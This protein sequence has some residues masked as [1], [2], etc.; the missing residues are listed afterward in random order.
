ML[1]GAHAI[2]IRPTEMV[3]DPAYAR[4]LV[5]I[6]APASVENTGRA[7]SVNAILFVV[8]LFSTPVVAAFGVGV[9][10]FSLVF[11]PAIAL[12]RGVETMTGQNIG[13]DKPDRAA[14]T[15]HFAAKVGFLLLAALGVVIFVFAPD[16]IRLF[17]D[18]P[19][20]VREGAT[21][22][23]WVAPTFGFA[24][25][26]RA[27]SGGFRGAGKTLTAAAIAILMFGFIRLPIAY[28]AS[29]DLLPFEF[30]I[31]GART[32]QGI[33]LAFAASSVVA[34]VI[35]YAWFRRG[36]WREADLTDDPT[37][38]AGPDPGTDPDADPADLTDD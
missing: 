22:L 32:P 27:Y 13:A 34:A 4:K 17:D 20:V 5:R 1:P 19:E 14:A 38:E 11:M 35:A 8:T 9:R 10:V 29:Q 3:P 36:T 7:V 2:R 15:A 21:F 6:G 28:V 24:G 25:I 33:W 30:W 18:N 23:R 16:V 26:L 12:D 31:F 37:V